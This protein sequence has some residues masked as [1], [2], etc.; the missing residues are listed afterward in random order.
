MQLPVTVGQAVEMRDTRV[1]RGILCREGTYDDYVAREIES[2]YGWMSVRGQRVLDIGGNI[3]AYACSAILGGAERVV[4]IEPEASNYAC[5]Q[6]N[7]GRALRENPTSTQMHRALVAAE[8]GVGEIW[9]SPTGKNP[10][11]TSSVKYRGRV[12]QGEIP[13]ISFGEILE[14]EQPSVLKIDVEGAEYDF[15]H[16][17]PL[18]DCVRQVTMEIHLSRP[19]WRQT[20]GPAIAQSFSDWECVREP[21]FEGGHWQTIGAWR[22]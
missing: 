18:P 3:G 8:A 12:S 15:F 14:R 20:L 16:S 22:R 19:S 6:E 13:Q 2:T 11:N 21:V 9:L 17:A 7:V 4:T 1:V 10:G 5:L